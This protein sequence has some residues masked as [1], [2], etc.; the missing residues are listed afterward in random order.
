[1]S[2]GVVLF[3]LMIGGYIIY[4]LVVVGIYRMVFG[5]ESSGLWGVV[6][7]LI[8]LAPPVLFFGNMH[9]RS[10]KYQESKQDY[11]SAKEIFKENLVKACQNEATFN[12]IHKIPRQSG[13]FI[14]PIKN[15][16]PYRDVA[17]N[18]YEQCKKDNTTIREG[19]YHRNFY[20]RAKYL[21]ALKPRQMDIAKS[22]VKD[23]TVINIESISPSSVDEDRW[24]ARHLARFIAQR[25][26][27]DNKVTPPFATRAATKAWWIRSGQEK[28]VRQWNK[29]QSAYGQKA[30]D[31]LKDEKLITL[32]IVHLVAD[33]RF[34]F[35]EIST[36]ADREQGL[37][38]FRL[39]LSH[40]QTDK[41]L[42]EYFGFDTVSDRE[43]FSSENCFSLAKNDEE[44]DRYDGSETILQAF[45]T[46][47]VDESK[48][49]PVPR[50]YHYP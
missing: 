42:A 24:E 25:S 41:L 16:A 44:K 1:M 6:F 36:I 46:A 33:Y 23:A 18:W 32:P 26:I 7:L 5:N 43:Y 45:F 2:L 28:T 39:A 11:L 3:L 47:V 34:R 31:E 38:R 40:R 19:S 10:K 20:C 37:R 30:F 22:L 27:K 21:T 12:I 29:E 4:L 14:E 8:A 35:E 15:N 49:Q 13:V 50:V 17:D 48:T 9:L